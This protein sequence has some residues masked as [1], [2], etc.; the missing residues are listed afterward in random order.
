MKQFGS[1]RRAITAVNG[2]RFLMSAGDIKSR[3][4]KLYGVCKTV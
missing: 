3:L 2:V 4:L 1:Q